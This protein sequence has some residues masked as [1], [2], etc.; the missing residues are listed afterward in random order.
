MRYQKGRHRGTGG[1][2]SQRTGPA[3]SHPRS[4][5]QLHGRSACGVRARTMAIAMVTLAFRLESSQRGPPD[6]YSVHR[7]THPG[8]LDGDAMVV[9]CRGGRIGL[10]VVTDMGSLATPSLLALVVAAPSRTDDRPSSDRRPDAWSALEPGAD[11]IPHPTPRPRRHWP[12]HRGGDSWAAAVGCRGPAE[13]DQ[14]TAPPYG[15]SAVPWGSL[16]NH[17][18][19]EPGANSPR[20]RPARRITCRRPDLSIFGGWPVGHLW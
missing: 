15:G 6:V 19:P 17:G 2:R 8:C 18:L 1:R 5:R 16:P 4:P 3:T 20:C 13:I 12:L 9:V 10:T 7:A 11:G 14:W